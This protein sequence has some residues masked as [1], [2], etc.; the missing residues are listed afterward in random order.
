MVLLEKLSRS[1]HSTFCPSIASNS[2]HWPLCSYLL[3]HTDSLCCRQPSE[4]FVP[5]RQSLLSWGATRV[6]R[7]WI[8]E[9][10]LATTASR[11]KY[12]HIIDSSFCIEEEQFNRNDVLQLHYVFYITPRKRHKNTWFK[13]W[14]HF[15]SARAFEK[16]TEPLTHQLYH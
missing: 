10:L 4:K 16:T 9:C 7:W 13:C 15:C 5:C 14:S 8:I 6:Q 2:Q 3:S 12:T 1:K 11:R